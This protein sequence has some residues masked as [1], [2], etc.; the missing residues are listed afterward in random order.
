M[1]IYLVGLG[2]GDPGQLTVQAVELLQEAETV[3][4]RTRRHPTVR[5]LPDGPAYHSFDDVYEQE[6]DFAA[7]YRR[8]V[9]RLVELA[10]GGEEVVYAVPGDPLVGEGT[11]TLLLEACRRRGIETV[12]VSGLSFVEPTLA[13]L[14]VDALDGLQVVDAT[15]L[16]AAYHPPINPD[17]PALIAQLY[18][19]RLAADVKLTLMNQYPDEHPVK[20]V[21]QAGTADQRVDSLLLY[22]IDRQELDHLTTLYL[23]PFGPSAAAV[24]SFEGFQNTIAHLRAPEGCPWDRE[25]T[26]ESLRRNLI[27]EAYEVVDAIDSG[28]PGRLREELGDLLI[29]VILHGQIAVDEGEF[30]MG[31]V[32]REVDEKIKRRHPHVWGDVEV[33]GSAEQVSI[34]WE[35]IKAQEREQKGEPEKSV[36]DGISKSLPALHQANEY[37]VRA[38]RVG[39]DWQ[40]EEGVLDKIQ[41]EIEEVLSAETPEEQFQEIGDL[42]LVVAVWA[43]WLQVNPEDALR[44]ANQ[45]FYDRFTQ[46]ERQAR[47]QGRSI[48]DLSEAEL[49]AIW[50]E[51]KRTLGAGR[52]GR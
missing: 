3:Y 14:G 16:A 18:S 42:L 48:A 36:L 51:A 43:R 4:L 27:E 21:Y 24:A 22:E 19:R 11:V 6:A 33:N 15:D 17:H 12:I 46:V 37:D 23:P 28:E 5:G 30:L 29:Q 49:L 20:L 13:L 35:K 32:I 10:E 31:D 40:S 8:I 50:E 44:A 39:F 34:N 47:K 7:V 26:H 45:R 2:P 9:D 38:V 52:D 25:Q 41:E 1:A